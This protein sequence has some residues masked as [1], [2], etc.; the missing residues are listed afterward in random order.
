MSGA[1]LLLQMINGLADASTLFL[2]AVGLSLVFGV[3]RIVNFAHGSFYM[4][5]LYLANTLIVRIGASGLGFWAAILLSATVVALIGLV[6]EIALLRR[7]YRSPELFQLLATFA[8]VLIIKDAALYVWGPDDVLGPRAPGLAGAF[9]ILGGRIPQY[10]VV[11]MLIAPTVLLF[12]WLWLNRTRSGVLIRAATEDRDMAGALGI[13]QAWLFSGVFALGC[14][15]AGLGG[16][17][18]VPRVPANLGLDLDSIADA[19]VVVVMGGIGSVTGTFIAALI[20]AELKVM[21]IGIG[22]ISLAGFVIPLAK[23]TQ[24]IEFLLMIGVLI[25]KPRGLL[26]K[27]Q[28]QA[29]RAGVQAPLLPLGRPR[30]WLVMLLLVGLLVAPL[31]ATAFPYLSVLLVEILIA[32]L[33]AAS[34]HF[35]LGPGNIQSFGHAAYFGLGGYGA[36]LLLSRLH[37]PMEA[38]F[39]LGP[40]MAGGGALMFGYFCVR[41]SGAYLAML[42]LAFTQLVWAVVSQWDVLGGSNGLIGIWPAPWLSSPTAYFYLALA[43]SGLGVYLLRRIVFSPFGLALRAS[44]DSALR[45][46]ALGINVHRV[47]WLAFSISGAFCGW[48]GVLFVFS[49]GGISPEAVGVGRSV[50]GL[51]MVVLGGIQSLTGPLAGAAVLTWLYDT[52]ARESDYW[53]AVLGLILLT[54]VLLFPDGIAG[55]RARLSSSVGRAPA[56]DGV[57]NEAAASSVGNSP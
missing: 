42:T 32:G 34:L 56:V 54:L 23:L 20:I 17:L 21:C 10:D 22:Q 28:V 51:A 37:L 38:A 47:Q 11:L 30:R 14:F 29:H 1:S 24:V 33:F 36:A 4:L 55:W 27:R 12:L 45:A 3:S 8:L 6:L 52:V 31:G 48:A 13:N 2:M 9:E 5:G 41:L 15:L 7:V 53:H 50:D 18:Q 40:L 46:D 16:A 49:K 35:I 57:S 19:F 25:V 39:L 44:R 26:G 43:C